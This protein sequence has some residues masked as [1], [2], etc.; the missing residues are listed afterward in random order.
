MHRKN[1]ACASCHQRMDPLGFAL[2]NFDALGK[3]RTVSDGAP[4]DPSASFPDGT[5]FE[6]VAG[7]RT[8]LVSHKEDFVR[9]LSGEAA[10]LR[11][12]P[13]PRLSRHARRPQRSRAMRRPPTT[14]GHRSSPASSRARRSAWLSRAGTRAR[15]L[16]RS[17]NDHLEERVIPRRTVLRGLGSMLALPLLDSMVPALSALQ[18]TAAKPINRFGV[19]YVPNGMIMKNYLPSIEGAALRADADV[20]RAR[21]VSRA[22]ARAERAGVHSDAGAARR[23][24]RE[25]QHALSD[26]RLAADE[27]DLA[28]RRHLDGSDPGAGDRQADAAGVARTGDR[29][30]RDGGRL[31]HRVRLSLHEHDQLEEPE[32]AAADAEQ[33]ARGVRAPV[34]RQHQ[35]GSEGA[36]G[37]AAAAAKRAR[38]GQRGGRAPAGSAAAERSHEADR[39]SRRHPRRRAAHPDRRAAERSANCRWSIIPPAFPPAGKIT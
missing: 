35:H 7:L 22:G 38:L 17:A 25:G 36:A 27:R 23:R 9:T 12:R 1:P 24:A 33:P 20:E 19:M 4:I 6:G 29:V 34:R 28:R 3:W 10:G 8:L 30:R 26:R 13:R 5:R 15:Q 11:D 2:E 39:V 31:R 21:A 16:E 14:P 37:A 18:K 32:H